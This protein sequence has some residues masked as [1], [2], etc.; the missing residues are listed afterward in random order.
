MH[1]KKT[2]PEIT[3]PRKNP[4]DRHVLAMILA[5]AGSKGLPS[6]NVLPIAGK[7]LI[8]Y[9][10]A[11]AKAAETIDAV[12]VTTDMPKA[13]DVTRFM[14]VFIVDRPP[15]LASDSATVDS[16]VRHAVEEYERG[17]RVVTHVAILYGN[18]PVRAPGV[19]DKAV[20]HLIETGCDSVR[21][22]TRVEKQHPDWLH[23]L[24]G[25]RLVQYRKNSIYR[26]QDLEALYYHDGAVLA[27]T[28]KSLSITSRD[29][30]HA[31][32][33]KDRR[34]VVS[35][36]GPT[37]DV[38]S[39]EDLGLAEALIEKRIRDDAATMPDNSARLP[40]AIYERTGK[41]TT[42]PHAMHQ[43]VSPT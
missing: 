6:K 18:V 33:G 14:G 8:A 27:V 19:I 41:S 36:G 17:R 24:V 22:V 31:F 16:A 3:Q 30:D 13:A 4:A 7:P 2:Q 42:A 15:D 25:D 39:F 5:R 11:E 40:A 37:I 1:A 32:L 28:R 29:D 38:D 12:C 20:S 9:T 21:S 35:E 23:R 26:R 43:M 34:A 10:I